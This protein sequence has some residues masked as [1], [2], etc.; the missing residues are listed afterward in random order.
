MTEPIELTEQQRAILDRRL[1]AAQ[2][3]VEAFNEAVALIGGPGAE[4]KAEEGVVAV[5][6]P[7]EETGGTEP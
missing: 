2:R 1:Q 4:Y 5:P 3:A 7:A 6:E